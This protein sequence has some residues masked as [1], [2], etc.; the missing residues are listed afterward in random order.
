[1]RHRDN[2]KTVFLRSLRI[3]KIRTNGT[4]KHKSRYAK[5][6][7]EYRDIVYYK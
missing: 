5:H 6:D 7:L 3:E 2:H 4:Y 1:M